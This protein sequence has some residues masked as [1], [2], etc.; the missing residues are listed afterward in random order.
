MRH[1]SA[2]EGHLGQLLDLIAVPESHGKYNAWY[3]EADQH[4]VDLSTLTLD[5]V[6][7]F[8]QQLLD[9][10]TGVRRSGAISSSPRRS[11]I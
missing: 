11:G 9:S 10:E 8:Q 1:S 3:N 4:Q 2:T 6:R 7:A 5:Q